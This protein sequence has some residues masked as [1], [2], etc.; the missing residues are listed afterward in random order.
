MGVPIISTR[1]GAAEEIIEDGVNGILINRTTDDLVA[2]LL[3]IR[4]DND[5]R[6]SMGEKIHEEIMRNW[7]WKVRIDGFRKMFNLYFESYGK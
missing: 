3:K 4:S 7:S 1:S 5:L 6:Y 2:A